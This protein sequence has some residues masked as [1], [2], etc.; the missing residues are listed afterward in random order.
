MNT[1]IR[2]VITAAIASVLASGFAIPAGAAEDSSVRKITVKFAD[3]NVSTPEGA[4][5][6]YARIR[7]A[8]L[9]V[10]GQQLDQM[11][12]RAATNGCVHKAIADA[13]TKVN[14]PALIAVYN[15][16]YKPG[17]PTRLLSQTR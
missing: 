11:W 1:I 14:E 15:E 4:A 16:N 8:A 17:L 10:C 3:L 13:V 2:H 6:L 5:A 12:T 7:T 9:S